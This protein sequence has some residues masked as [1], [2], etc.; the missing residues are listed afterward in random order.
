MPI[1]LKMSEVVKKG[2]GGFPG[3]FFMDF[4]SEAVVQGH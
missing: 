1:K 3:P 4:C 2:P